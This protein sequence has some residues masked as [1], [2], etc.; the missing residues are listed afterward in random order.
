MLKTMNAWLFS[1]GV[2]QPQNILPSWSNI[3][4]SGTTLDKLA[5]KMIQKNL[6]DCVTE[7]HN[8]KTVKIILFK[9]RI[10]IKTDLNMNVLKIIILPW[11]QYTRLSHKN[12]LTF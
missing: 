6:L 1:N 11:T 10:K 2:F 8:F 12:F 5:S 9:I 4:S 7:K 3:I